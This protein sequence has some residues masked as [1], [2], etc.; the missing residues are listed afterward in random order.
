MF[1]LSRDF[2]RTVIVEEL[3]YFQDFEFPKMHE[4]VGTEDQ[5]TL[6]KALCH[7]LKRY[8]ESNPNI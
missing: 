7:F 8:F 5:P 3:C 4:Y 2:P 1:P 6:V